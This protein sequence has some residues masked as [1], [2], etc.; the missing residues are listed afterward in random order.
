MFGIGMTKGNVDARNFLVL[1]NIADDA[2]ASDVGADGK[3]AHAVAVLVRAGVGAKLFE[4]SDASHCR[5]RCGY[6]SHRW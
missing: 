2:S 4:Q 6:P 3:L 1:Q 5:S